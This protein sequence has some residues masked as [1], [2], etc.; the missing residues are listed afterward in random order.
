M[1]QHLKYPEKETERESEWDKLVIKNLKGK[2][3]TS[4]RTGVGVKTR[5]YYKFYFYPFKWDDEV[6]EW[7]ELEKITWKTISTWD[8]VD[9]FLIEPRGKETKLIYTM[10]YTPPYWIFGRIWYRLF[11]HKHLEKHLEYVL[12]QM[13]RSAEEI[14][15]FE[16]KVKMNRFL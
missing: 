2:A 1:V 6:I 7:K 13:K 11:V 9:S 10:R 12:R 4:N 3:L 16:Q 14:A 15:K 8:M 5:W